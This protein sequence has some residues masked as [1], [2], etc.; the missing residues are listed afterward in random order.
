MVTKERVGKLLSKSESKAKF[1]HLLLRLSDDLLISVN[2]TTL[3]YDSVS[4]ETIEDE[5][6]SQNCG[7]CLDP[8]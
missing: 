6:S 3:P 8:R 5:V 4:Q 2:T 1:V 7:L